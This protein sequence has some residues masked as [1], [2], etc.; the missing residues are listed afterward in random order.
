MIPGEGAVMNGSTK[1]PGRSSSAARKSAHSRPRV[2]GVDVAHLT[3]RLRRLVIADRLARRQHLRHLR[4]QQPG[5]ARHRRAANASSCRRT[6]SCDGGHRGKNASRCCSPLLPMSMPA[7]ICLSRT[8]RRAALPS[9][10]SSAGSTE[11]A[12]GALD[13][14]AGQLGR[15]RQ[16]AGMRRQDA[17]L[18][19][20]HHQPS[21]MSDGRFT[22]ASIRR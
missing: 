9:R 4:L 13:I 3:D 18:A 21:P 11:V 7:S 17:V 16:A 20:L 6:R 22:A 1:A 10:S 19:P 2:R 15:S 14:E 5:S 12:A 8:C